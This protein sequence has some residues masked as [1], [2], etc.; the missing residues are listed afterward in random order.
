MDPV[1]WMVLAGIAVGGCFP[2]GSQ[3]E[4]DS[5]CGGSFQC[6]RTH[7][8]VDG[9]L[10]DARLTW[11]IGGVTADATSCAGVDHMEITFTDTATNDGT[12][13][14]PVPCALGLATYD[15]MPPRFDNVSLGAHDASDRILDSATRSLQPGINQLAFDLTP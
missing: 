11:T 12:T 6:T 10:I 14:S 3:C 4:V 5:D 15:K 8:C 9:T 2:S 1:R 13:Y 7:E